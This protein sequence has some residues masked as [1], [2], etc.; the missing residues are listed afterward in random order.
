MV[1]RIMPDGVERIDP[2][3]L[4]WSGSLDDVRLAADP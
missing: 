4:G 2:V 3:A 1:A